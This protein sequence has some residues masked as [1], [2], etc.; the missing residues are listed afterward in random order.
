MKYIV[1]FGRFWYDFIVGD[2]AVLAIGG[3][4][5]LVVGALLARADLTHVADVALP[6]LVTGTL[7]VSLRGTE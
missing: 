3:A 7:A 6:V 2:S 1:G 4:A 5:A